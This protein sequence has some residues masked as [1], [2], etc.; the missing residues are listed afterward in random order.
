MVSHE[1]GTVM[2]AACRDCF[3]SFVYV[4]GAL[5]LFISFITLFSLIR[6]TFV[7]ICC[8]IFSILLV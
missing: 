7:S 8:N 5:V 1:S 3:F 2:M 4:F 6:Y